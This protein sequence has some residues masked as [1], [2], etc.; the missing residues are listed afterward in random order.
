MRVESGATVTGA[1]LDDLDDASS[2]FPGRHCDTREDPGRVDIEILWCDH[3]DVDP[4]W[5]N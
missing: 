5:G 3:F 1:V 4:D 2:C